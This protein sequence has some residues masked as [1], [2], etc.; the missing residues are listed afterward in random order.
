ML[1]AVQNPSSFSRGALEFVDSYYDIR[2]AY[3]NLNKTYSISGYSGALPVSIQNMPEEQVG[4]VYSV[5][6]GALTLVQ[7]AKEDTNGSVAGLN[8]VS[9]ACISPAIRPTH[10]RPASRHTW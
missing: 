10:S 5:G 4:A 6:D 7:Y 8:G 2:Y 3:D 9:E 1:I